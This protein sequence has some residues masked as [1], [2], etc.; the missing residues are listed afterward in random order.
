M[1]EK[2]LCE[3]FGDGQPCQEALALIQVLSKVNWEILNLRTK[4][5]ATLPLSAL[6]FE[7]LYRPSCPYLDG[8]PPRGSWRSI[9]GPMGCDPGTLA[10]HR[11]LGCELKVRRSGY[12]LYN[13]RMQ[14]LKRNFRHCIIGNLSRIGKKD[15]ETGE[16]EVEN[17]SSPTRGK[18]KRGA[19]V[20]HPGWMRPKAG[21]Y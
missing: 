14:S 16:K 17:A 6:D 20:G 3:G 8:Y 1:S 18:K 2:I 19:P 4:G 12:A 11:W 15:A 21:P 13:G 10:D 9:D 7:C 5:R